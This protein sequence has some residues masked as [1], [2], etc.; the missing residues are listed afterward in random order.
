MTKF[1]VIASGKGGVGKTTASLN[2]G[3]AL[4][5]F[6]RDVIV[7]D[8][9]VSKPNIGLHLGRNKLGSSLNDVLKGNKSIRE[10][11]YMHPSGLKV[12]PNSIN[13]EDL[14]DVEIKNLS[15]SL[16]ELDGLTEIVI[17]DA[18]PGLHEEAV[19]AIRAADEI[20]IVTTPDLIAVTD[21][22][23]TIQIAK[24]VG[25]KVIGII[26]NRF[27]GHP[28]DMKPRNIEL[29]LETKIIGIIPED[30]NIKESLRL[31]HPVT[32]SHPES[33]SSI[34]FKKI[35]AFLIGEKYDS[36]LKIDSQ[37]EKILKKTGIK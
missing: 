12:V 25:V 13:I 32:Y 6:G 2:I 30:K 14:K 16:K 24:K 4:T 17:I 7:I 28:S 37:F 23:K 21:A 33:Q 11:V 3:N 34:N 31:K 27:E 20:I 9:N 26:V 36:P 1:I 35:A 19:E 8:A 29:M 15:K 5:D 22:L 10:V 18:A